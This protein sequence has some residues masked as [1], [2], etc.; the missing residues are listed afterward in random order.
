MKL[1]K[2][3]CGQWGK[4]TL[5]FVA[6]FCLMASPTYG[7]KKKME[8]LYDF[9]N[10]KT[11]VPKIYNEPLSEGGSVP[12]FPVPFDNAVG[13]NN[14]L[15]GITVAS[16]PQGK[17]RLDQYFKREVDDMRG[18]GKYLPVISEHEV[19]FAQDRV[20]YHCNFK[21]KKCREHRVVFSID[22]TIENLAVSDARKKWF[23]FEVKEYN[24]RSE[25]HMDS[26][27]NL[28]LVDV[29]GKEPKVIKEKNIG[30]G[31]IWTAALDRVFLWHF[32]RKVLE[33]FDLNLE[34]AQHPLGETIKR[35][36]N[37]LDWFHRIYPHTVLPFAIL[38]GGEN[39][40]LLSWDNKRINKLLSLFGKDNSSAQFSFSPDG[41]WVTFQQGGVMDNKKTCLMPVSDKYPNYLGTPIFLMNKTFDLEDCAWTKNPVS[42]VCAHSDRVFRWEFTKEAQKSIMG[43]DA[44]KYPTFHDYIVAKDLEKLTKEKKQGLGE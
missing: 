33:V 34:P 7:G 22:E 24:S 23:I 41:K 30:R 5:L 36:K 6:V 42:L 11:I 19:G 44:D 14:Y 25:D 1:F 39:E 43:N 8:S 3:A 21:T 38:T 40:M 35:Y 15:N 17:F 12:L 31:S 13:T 20:F 2:A 10:V 28:Q 16:F 18:S 27:Y 4:V 32:N 29:S 9:K 37:Q 26:T